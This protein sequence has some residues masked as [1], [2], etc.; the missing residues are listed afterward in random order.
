VVFGPPYIQFFNQSC[1]NRNTSAVAGQGNTPEVVKRHD[2]KL[3]DEHVKKASE[4]GAIRDERGGAESGNATAKTLSQI[5][6]NCVAAI[7]LGQESSVQ[8]NSN[9]TPRGVELPLD[10]TGKTAN[11]QNGGATGGAMNCDD[12]LSDSDLALLID[13]WPT[14]PA[15]LRQ[16]ILAVVR[17][18]GLANNSI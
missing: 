4:S 16:H 2:L 1:G 3:T 10:S 9:H 5:V 8:L 14:L 11:L 15:K 6:A 12:A 18:G 17:D 7:E 13:R